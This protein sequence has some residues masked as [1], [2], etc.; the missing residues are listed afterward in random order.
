[1]LKKKKSQNILEYILV[2][3]AIVIAIILGAR[4][5]IKPAV[6]TML[7]DSGEVITTKSDEFYSLAGG[8]PINATP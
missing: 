2:L 4:A 1:M 6:Q 8:G 3:T 7:E 5:Y